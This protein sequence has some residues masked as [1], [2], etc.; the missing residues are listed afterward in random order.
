VPNLTELAIR[1]FK[2]GLY[3][4]DRTPAFGIRVG[5]NRKTWIVLREPNRTKVTIGHYPAL[6]L[7]DARKKAMAT[8]SAPPQQQSQLTFPQAVEMFLAQPRWRESSKRV[9]TSSLRHFDWKRQLNKITHEDVA[10]ALEAISGV[11]ARAHA[12]KDIRTFFNWCV[13]RYLPSSPC[14]GMKMD[15]QPSRDRV[16]SDDELKRVWKAAETAGYPF[17]TIVRLLILTGQRKSE[18]GNLR[19]E[20]LSDGFGNLPGAITKNGREHSFAI[21]PWASALIPAKNDRVTGGVRPFV[22][23]AS[24]DKLKPYNGY[25]FHLKQLQK[26]SQTSGWTL[27]DLR[28][29]F[30]TNLAALGVPVHVAEKQINHASGTLSGVAAIY[31]RYSY[32]EEMAEAVALW[33]GQLQKVVGG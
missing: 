20:H 17:G 10:S 26:A 12:L 21:G 16:L 18:I 27:H 1:N 30:V 32:H 28:R 11:S 33:E 22:F 6:G 4:D 5:K 31:N 23:S 14:I 24:N 19:W 2:P 3:M 15:T 29:T 13:P 8:L 25:T 9:L 7:S